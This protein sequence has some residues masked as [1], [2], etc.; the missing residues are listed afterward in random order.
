MREA[1]GT[2]TFGEWL[3]DLPE[4]N[5]PGLTEAL[6]VLPADGSYRSFQTFDTS[7][8]QGSLPADVVG[9]FSTYQPANAVA[10]FAGTRT[11]LYKNSGPTSSFSDLSSATYSTATDGYWSWEQYE[12]LIIA[13]N[14]VDSPQHVTIN[15]SSSFSVLGSSVGTAP[16]ARCIGR[17][18]QF[19]MLGNVPSA[20][21][22]YVRWCGIDNPLS[23]PTPGSSTAVAQQSGEQYFA[24]GDGEVMSISSGDQF[25]I[26]FQRHAITRVTYV[27][28]DVVFQ[29]DNINSG[30]GVWYPNA[31]VQVGGVTYFIAQDGFYRTNGVQ[32]DP[33]GVGKIDRWFRANVE[34]S[35][36]HRVYGAADLNQNLIYWAFPESGSS[37]GTPTHL[38]I[39][40]LS[41]NRFTHAEQPL[42]ALV[43]GP[44]SVTLPYD[45]SFGTWVKGFSTANAL[46]Y[47]SGDPGTAVLTTGEFEGTPGGRTFLQGVKPFVTGTSPAVTVAIGTRNSQG[48]S[49]TYTAERTAT[50]RT[51][52]AD[53]RSEAR[54]HRARVT[55]VG[56]FDRAIGVQVQTVPSG[57]V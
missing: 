10:V 38:L 51:G 13:C 1:D 30:R 29:F 12:N 55:I 2:F 49:V 26:V 20:S 33:I 46:G 22:A 9:A 57:P 24:E 50:A 53:F 3:P 40:S 18:G 16:A 11:R 6:N 28:G 37:D 47:F 48:E 35:F 41:E 56:A 23:W 17:I 42:N 27:G 54:F 34:A 4:L 45:E 43:S 31:T 7:F 19:I 8:T 21:G 52:F 44:P 15:S 39:Y 25:A 5:N 14:G 32:V 36:A